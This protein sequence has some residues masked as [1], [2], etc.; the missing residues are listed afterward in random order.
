MTW[1]NIFVSSDNIMTF[2][3]ILSLL[4]IYFILE[5]ENTKGLH[6][7]ITALYFPVLGM[8]DDQCRGPSIKEVDHLAW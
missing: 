7:Y 2:K 8:L 6:L 5:L 3:I 1:E 4:S